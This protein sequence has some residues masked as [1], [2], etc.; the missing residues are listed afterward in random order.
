MTASKE[1]HL[2]VIQDGKVVAILRR[3]DESRH[4]VLYAVSEMDE[5]MIERLLNCEEKPV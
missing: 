5:T 3:D 4:W 1:N 2:S